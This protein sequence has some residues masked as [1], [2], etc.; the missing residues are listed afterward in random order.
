MAIDKKLIEKLLSAVSKRYHEAQ[1]YVRKKHGRG[2]VN[3]PAIVGQVLDEHKIKKGIERENYFRELCRRGGRAGA[4]ARKTQAASKKE[5]LS[6]LKEYFESEEY[7]R[8]IAEL[9]VPDDGE[10]GG[11]SYVRAREILEKEILENDK[12][13]EDT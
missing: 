4:K 12:N 6:Y 5:F 3:F 13:G 1:E 10:P 11:L 2:N 8:D 9:R 7:I